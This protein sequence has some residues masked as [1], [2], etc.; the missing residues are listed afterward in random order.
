MKIDSI[1]KLDQ[2]QRAVDLFS[3]LSND[4]TDLRDLNDD[5]R[6]Y[7]ALVAVPDTHKVK[8]IY[9]MGYGTQG[10]GPG[11]PIANKFLALFGEGGHNIGLPPVLIFDVNVRTIAQ[12]L[13]PDDA[14]VQTAFQNGHVLG[15]SVVRANNVT[16]QTNI[17]QVVPIPAYFVL[18]GLEDDLEAA[19]VYERLL[20]STHVSLMRTHALAFLRAVLVGNFRQVDDKPFVPGES[21]RRMIP[22]QGR[23]WGSTRFTT[24][25]PTINAN[26]APDS[27]AQQPN[28]TAPHAQ[29]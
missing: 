9:G 5:Q 2:R 11:S 3:F 13:T 1:S 21:F 17:I 4:Q 18:D 6:I 14:T 26:A 27:S 16:T 20:Q 19:V 29:I 23:I 15:R 28:G 7:T 25:F 24:L 8:V 10:V 12:V 22:S